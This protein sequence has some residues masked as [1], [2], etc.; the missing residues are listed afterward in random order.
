[1][2]HL[3]KRIYGPNVC[4]CVL[5]HL[6]KRINGP[7]VCYCVLTHLLTLIYGPQVCYCVLTSPE[8]S[9]PCVSSCPSIVPI[10]P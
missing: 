9:N 1:M 3:L 5:T 7:Q 2:T 8:L 6:L 10:A 4:Y